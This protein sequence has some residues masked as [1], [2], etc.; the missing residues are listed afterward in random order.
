M[1]LYVITVTEFYCRSWFT[2]R[3]HDLQHKTTFNQATI[4]LCLSTLQSSLVQM[5]LKFLKM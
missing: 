5:K 1:Y 3:N 2:N 4:S